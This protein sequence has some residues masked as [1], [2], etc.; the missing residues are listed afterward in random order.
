MLWLLQNSPKSYEF[1]SS[2]SP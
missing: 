1:T 2:F